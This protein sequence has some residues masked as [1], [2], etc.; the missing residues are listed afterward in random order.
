[1]DYDVKFNNGRKLT[2]ASE[3]KLAKDFVT[4]LPTGIIISVKNVK[5]EFGCICFYSYA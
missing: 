5:V 3:A 1:L 4:S 2:L